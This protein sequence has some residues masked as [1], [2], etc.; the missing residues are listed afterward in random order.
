M[1]PTTGT[2]PGTESARAVMTLHMTKQNAFPHNPRR[3]RRSRM[4]RTCA[5]V[6]ALAVG[7]LA[8]PGTASASDAVAD[9]ARAALPDAGGITH[10]RMKIDF[11][12]AEP[13]PVHP[14]SGRFADLPPAFA[15]TEDDPPVFTGEIERWIATGPLRDRTAWIHRFSNGTTGSDE[16]SYADGEFREWNSTER[17]VHVFPAS[18]R[19]RAEYEQS[20][21]GNQREWLVNVAWG[22]D[23]VAAVRT[24]LDGGMLRSAGRVTHEGRSVLRL[25]GEEPGTE[26]NG[27]PG[28]PIAYEYLVEPHTFAPVRA[29]QTNTLRAPDEN[30]NGAERYVVGWSFSLYERLPLDASTE[31]LLVAGGGR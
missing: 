28:G 21:L 1:R 8:L 9:A 23:P 24:M 16:R 25:I 27:S 17:V 4:L 7:G 14:L 26:Q 3:G 2:L 20:R 12:T 11:S 13:A 5:T 31:H 15:D 10:I 6:A 29:S 22:A 30:G 18:P 19:E